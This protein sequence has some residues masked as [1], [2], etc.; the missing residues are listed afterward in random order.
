MLDTE[1][2]R[3][4]EDRAILVHIDRAKERGP[5]DLQ[6]LQE[7]QALAITAGVVSL[8]TI[9]VRLSAVNP[10]YFIGQGKAEELAQA[11]K[12]HKSSLILF[13]H[14]L[15]PAQARN[16]ERLCHCRIVD[17]TQLILDIF[18]QRAHS[19]EGKLQVELAQLRHLSSRLVRGWTHLE[20]Q[21]G[22]VGLRGPGET[23]LESDRRAIRQRIDN[24]MGRLEKLQRQRQQGMRARRRARIPIV[25]LVGYTNAGKS[26]LFNRLTQAE[27]YTD[28]RLFATLDPTMRR[29]RLGGVG[30]TLLVDTVGFIR[31]LPHQLIAA[32]NTTLQETKE[33]TLLLHVADG[34]D[35]MLPQ[36][37]TAVQEVLR[38]IGADHLP[39]LLVMNKIDQIAGQEPEIEYNQDGIPT[40]VWLSATKGIGSGQ[41][42]RAL[43]E[44]LAHKR[45]V[46]QLQFPTEEFQLR[47][48]L[49]QTGAIVE[50]EPTENG[51]VHMRVEM[52]LSEWRYLTKK[53]AKLVRFVI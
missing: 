9:V 31:N 33:A 3:K 41:L 4:I 50:E 29:I 22:G 5:E 44:S 20:R 16:L 6:D 38:E 42:L 14:E 27:V 17:R 40:R 47:S 45:V 25:A 18:A 43:G 46:Q 30:T 7:F 48:H 51:M 34:S 52:P 12:S 11:V 23:Q 1:L 8:H 24:L 49:Y 10:R 36:K 39:Q 21:R 26:T 15:S 19:Y 13:N 37:I 53:Y 35:P 2:T 28:D 32:F